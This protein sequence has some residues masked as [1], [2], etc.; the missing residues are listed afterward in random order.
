MHSR[1]GKAEVLHLSL[2]N[3]VLYRPR[4]IFDRNIRIHTVLVEKVYNVGSET[5]E[6]GLCHLLHVLGAAVEYRSTLLPRWDR[7]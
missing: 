6:R 3:Q 1:F 2:L 4:H 7:P 5:L